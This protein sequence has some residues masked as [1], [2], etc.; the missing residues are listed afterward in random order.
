MRIAVESGYVENI[1]WCC[2]K[3]R[4]NVFVLVKIVEFLLTLVKLVTSLCYSY[5]YT[6]KEGFRQCIKVIM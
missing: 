1:I 2:N 4:V 3:C 5:N 6:K